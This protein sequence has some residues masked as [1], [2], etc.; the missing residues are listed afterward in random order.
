MS[1]NTDNTEFHLPAGL[2]E[3]DVLEVALQR[4]F[5]TESDIKAAQAARLRESRR[6]L[7][8]PLISHLIEVGALTASQA[9]RL[10]DEVVN[11]SRVDDVPG[12][13]FLEQLG[14]GA[15]GMVYRARQLSLN[16]EVAVKLLSRRIVRN[17]QYVDLFTRE[18]ALAGRVNSPYFPRVYEAGLAHGQHFLVMEFV[19]GKSIE[20]LLRD[21]QQ[22]TVA[23]ALHVA[24][25]VCHALAGLHALQ[26]VHRD[27]KPH[28][29]VLSREGQIKLI[30][31]GLAFDLAD[32]AQQALEQGRAIGTPNYISP[33]QVQGSEGLC[34]QSD[35]YGL[36]ATLYHMTTGRPPFVLEDSNELLEAHV[37]QTPE[38]P[39]QHNSQIPDEVDRIITRLLDKHPG[40]RGSSAAELAEELSRPLSAL[41]AVAGV[42]QWSLLER[43]GL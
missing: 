43:L 1:T 13:Q 36:G 2:S 3:R 42:K 37:H 22:L 19:E 17:K 12:Y 5:V 25:E 27:V 39:R 15:M 18:A 31:L 30:D 24:V 16:R 40:H 8:R 21:R 33:E 7:Y 38:A 41:D 29:I 20:E 23:Q 34:P 10:V 28:N 14:N 35:L 32:P 11:P 6:D 26:I 9:G 4:G